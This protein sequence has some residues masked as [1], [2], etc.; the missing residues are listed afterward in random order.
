MFVSEY[1]PTMKLYTGAYPWLFPGG[2]GDVYDEERG[3]LDQLTGPVKSLKTWA[4]HL[5]Q[6]FDGRFQQCQMFMLYIYNTIQRQDN[7]K[8]GAFF[9][10]DKNWYGKNPPTVEEIKNQIRHGIFTFVSKLRY[11]S[12]TI[13]GT[14][15]YWRNK[16]D[17][18][19]AWIDFHVANGHGPPTHFITLTCAENWWPN[20]RDIYADLEK[21]AGREV[22]AQLLRQGN[23]QAMRRAA[24]RYPHYVNKYFMDRAKTFLDEFAR[25]VLEL[26]YYWGRIEFAPGRGAVHLHL[27]GIAQNKAYLH[28]FYQARSEKRKIK[29]LQKYAEDMLGMTADVEIDPNHNRFRENGNGHLTTSESPLGSRFSESRDPDL[30]H[31]QLAQDAVFHRCNEYCL[32]DEDKDGIR[33]RTCR[34]GYGTE[35]TSNKGDTPG[36]ELL[37]SPTIQKDARGIEHLLLPRYHSRKVNQHSRTIL[38]AWRANAD[39]QLIVYRSDPNV[40]DVGEIE[41]VSKYVTS[42]AVKTQKTTREEI[43]TIQDVIIR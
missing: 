28:N 38:Q 13:R 39:V 34:F 10:S 14:D 2:L 26:E 30:D 36:K 12:Q 5:M 29:V 1:D 18:L 3:G 37:S 7:N 8:S 24:R 4:R 19:R 42:Y 16:S 41:A 17:E 43:N 11:F 21:I 20:L 22:E 40:P 27:L 15:G 25:D 33:L 35:A 32:G 31:R 6:Y 23:I 9:H